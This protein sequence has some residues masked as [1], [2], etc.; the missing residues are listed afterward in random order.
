MGNDA[1][2]AGRIDNRVR[3]LRRARALT[4]IDLGDLLGVSRQTIN[5]IENGRYEPGLRLAFSIARVFAGRIEDVFQPSDEASSAW[6]SIMIT[7][8]ERLD[9]GD[10]VL[11]PHRASDLAA[12]QAFVADREA[13]RFM[14]FTA[15]QKTPGGAAAMMDAVIESYA[16]DAPICSLTIA[17]TEDGRYLGSVGGAE[18]G[19]GAME[20]F[21]TVL[22]GA[23]G[24]G[25]GTAAMRA[26]GDHLFATS[27]AT[28]L[29]ADVV[30]E[31]LPS[32]RLFERLGY[33]NAGPVER[34]ASEGAFGHR[35]MQGVR[36]V[37][38][39]KAHRTAKDRDR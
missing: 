6:G 25:V 30:A 20:V 26:L 24:R 11:R 22:P 10:V 29:R 14:A 13:T 1:D 27:G 2:R 4:Q 16:T 32:V 12:F 8:P 18:A 37:L 19:E 36:Y 7:I 38:T 34:A 21:V 15:E 28:E 5:A 39:A 33:R 23:Q 35:D 9:A 3:Q 17:D 31:N